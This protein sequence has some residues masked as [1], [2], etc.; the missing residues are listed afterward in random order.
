MT[1]NWLLSYHQ[2]K[3]V[4]MLLGKNDYNRDFYLPRSREPLRIV[5][6]EKDLGVI[7]NDKLSFSIHITEQV[8]K[9]NQIM[10]G[11]RK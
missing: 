4:L 8:N 5:N 9:A 10:G 2:D 3:Y 6:Q 11:I 7:F 1:E